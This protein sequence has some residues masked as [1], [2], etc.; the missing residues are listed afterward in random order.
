MNHV[1][2]FAR[3]LMEGS[4]PCGAGSHAGS[5]N[6]SVPVGLMAGGEIVQEGHL[7]RKI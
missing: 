5:D 7:L 3:M 4:F 2:G 1:S 6:R